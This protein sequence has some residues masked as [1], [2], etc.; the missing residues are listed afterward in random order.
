MIADNKLTENGAWSHKLLANH[1]IELS[2]L[3]PNFELEVTG[4]EMGEIDFLIQGRSTSETGDTAD[5]LQSIPLRPSVAKPGLIWLLGPHCVLCGN[6]LEPASCAALLEEE[7]ADLVFTKPPYNVRVHGHKD[8]APEFAIASGEMNRED[9]IDFLTTVCFQLKRFSQSGAKS[10]WI[11]RHAS[12][13][14]AA[15]NEIF[16]S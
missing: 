1:F 4:F 3:D 5:D 14:L 13:M 16:P 12:E 10:P 15:G 8:K 6:S 2:A 9:F 7:R 11:R